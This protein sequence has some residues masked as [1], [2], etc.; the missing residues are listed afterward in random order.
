MY[1]HGM[2]DTSKYRDDDIVSLREAAAILGASESTVVR[3][4]DEGKYG[5]IRYSKR[6]IKY[7]VG[8]LRAFRTQSYVRPVDYI[9]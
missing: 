4:R 3:Y 7:R 8:D 9:E 5:Y 2:I 1:H 6:N